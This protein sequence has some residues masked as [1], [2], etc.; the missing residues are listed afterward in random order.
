MGIFH[1]IW[2]LIVG[3][4][5]GLVARELVGGHM[6]LVMTTVLGIVGSLVGGFIAGLIWPPKDA[7]FHPAGFI[8]SVLGA[9]L[10][11]WCGHKFGY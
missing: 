3:F 10:V 7:R 11:L 2:A 4:F 1:V 8:F 6:G 9:A 5:A